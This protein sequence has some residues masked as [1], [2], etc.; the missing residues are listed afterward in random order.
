[1]PLFLQLKLFKK[2][3]YKNLEHLSYQTYFYVY[4]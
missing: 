2:D 4:S 3:I 1:M